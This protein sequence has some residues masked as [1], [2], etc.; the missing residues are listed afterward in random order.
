MHSRGL[1]VVDFKLMPAIQVTPVGD[2]AISRN[3]EH[4][5]SKYAINFVLTGTMTSYANGVIVNIR[6][7]DVESSVVVSTAQ[8]Q[9]PGRT[10][11]S[12]LKPVDTGKPK[13]VIA[14]PVD[15]NSRSNKI[16]L[17]DQDSAATTSPIRPIA[18]N[19]AAKPSD[20]SSTI[21]AA[22]EPVSAERIQQLLIL[23]QDSGDLSFGSAELTSLGKKRLDKFITSINQTAEREKLQIVGYTDSIGNAA[24]NKLL[25]TQ[26][27]GAVSTYLAMHNID[28]QEITVLGQGEESP[29]ASNKFEKG[30][31][32]NRRVEI[33]VID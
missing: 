1:K 5:K 10:Y 33:S 2:F 15:A 17:T 6:M 4:L 32:K 7:I 22:T 16:A 13:T 30:R 21:T 11:L 9:I 3:L 28:A 12:L 25:S 8:I 27:A 29:V 19:R 20:N 24:Y 23:S 14:E 26:R 31:K 18:V